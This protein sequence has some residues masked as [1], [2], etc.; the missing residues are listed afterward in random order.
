LRH[1]AHE[2]LPTLQRE[3][4][5][6]RI[7]SQEDR[8]AGSYC[9]PCQLSY[10]REHY[11]RTSGAYN[12]RRYILHNI[13][14]ERNRQYVLAH[15][16]EHPCV[17]CGE[18]DVVVLDFDHVNGKKCCSV[19]SMIGGA[20]S[21]ARVQAE[22]DKCV[23]RCSNCHRRKTARERGSYRLRMLLNPEAV[24]ETS[25]PGEPLKLWDGRGSNPR[26]MA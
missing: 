11:R 9:K 22:I 1:F 12:A 6:G 20:I 26:Q 2:D 23:V 14:T 19:S 8:E 15:L 18:S 13:Y 5:V 21:L 4:V 16:L 17:D 10:V 7:L 25:V 3:K 24:C